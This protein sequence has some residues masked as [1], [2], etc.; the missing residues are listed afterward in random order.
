VNWDELEVAF[1]PTQQT[2]IT[3]DGAVTV[4]HD[5]IA[6]SESPNQSH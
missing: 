4:P 1:D 6:K 3:P 5:F 2:I